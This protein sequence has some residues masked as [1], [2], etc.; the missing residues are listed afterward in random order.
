MPI[1]VKFSNNINPKD[2]AAT[3]D[4]MRKKKNRIWRRCYPELIK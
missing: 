1:E 2:L 3:T 4:F